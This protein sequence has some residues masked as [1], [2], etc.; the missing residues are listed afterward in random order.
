MDVVEAIRTLRAVRRYEA[1]PVRRRRF[2][3]S[4]RQDA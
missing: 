3:E 2:A 4:S 1:K